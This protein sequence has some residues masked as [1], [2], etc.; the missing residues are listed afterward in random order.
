MHG[1]LLDPVHGKMFD[2][3]PPMFS[4][5]ML[6]VIDTAPTNMFDL[7]ESSKNCFVIM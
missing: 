5:A 6:M 2:A 3:P 4:L 7:S 1:L